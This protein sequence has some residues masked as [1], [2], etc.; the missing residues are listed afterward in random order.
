MV[1]GVLHSKLLNRKALDNIFRAHIDT[2]SRL[3]LLLNERGI[4]RVFLIRFR[5][6]IKSMLRLWSLRARGWLGSTN[7]NATRGETMLVRVFA[8]LRNA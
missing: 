1:Y 6:V 2:S 5:C 4:Y 3:I 8:Y 7:E